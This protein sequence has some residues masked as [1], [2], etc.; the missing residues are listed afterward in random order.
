VGW[1]LDMNFSPQK[2]HGKRG[3]SGWARKEGPSQGPNWTPFLCTVPGPRAG[4]GRQKN[5]RGEA[6]W[7]TAIRKQGVVKSQRGKSRREESSKPII[8]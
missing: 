7:K 4:K 6:N 1:H 3:G 2:A 8:Y 5:R